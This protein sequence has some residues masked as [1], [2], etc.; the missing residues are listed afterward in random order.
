M[1]F[2][3]LPVSIRCSFQPSSCL[4]IGLRL[5]R[6]EPSRRFGDQLIMHPFRSRKMAPSIWFIVRQ[7]MMI[8]HRLESIPLGVS[9][10]PS[11]PREDV[12]TR[13][14]ETSYVHSIAEH[15]RRGFSAAADDAVT[16]NGRLQGGRSSVG[17][18][19]GQLFGRLFSSVGFWSVIRSVF[20]SVVRSGARS[21]GRLFG[22]SISCSVGFS[23]GCSVSCSFG[24][25]FG[26]SVSSSVRF[27]L[28]CSVVPSVLRSVV[29]S[30]FRLFGES[31]GRSFGRSANRS[32][33]LSV[34]C[35]VGR[36]VHRLSSP[37]SVWAVGCFQ[38]SLATPSS[39]FNN[40]LVVTIHTTNI[41]HIIV[42]SNSTTKSETW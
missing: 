1:L 4:S 42:S 24:W 23:V 25:S 21:V 31:F 2:D 36:S 29:R 22:C 27:S 18:W 37:P 20:R 9:D 32:F 34:G 8:M 30:V 10:V 5:S 12:R 11:A 7:P 33:G 6:A 17:R 13:P 14:G 39:C 35:S 16:I 38:Q 26:C 3:S 15:S 19:I 41:E 40:E 28:G